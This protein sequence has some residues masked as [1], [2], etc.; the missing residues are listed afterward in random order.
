MNAKLPCGTILVAISLAGRPMIALAQPS[1]APPV[2]AAQMPTYHF[3][4]PTGRDCM[5]FDPNGAIFYK[6]RYHLGYIYQEG[7]RHFWG[8]VSSTDLVHW[9][10]HPPMLSPGPES[11]IFSGN[12]F[13]DKKGRVVL[14]YHGLGDAAAKVPAG[15]CLAIAQDDDLDVFRKLE[16][17]PVMKN[18]GWDPHT[19]QENGTYYSIS[20]GN[21]GSGN[22]PSLY[23]STDDELA[24]W[25]LVGPL[26]SR[27][28]PGVF[29]NEDIS[30][31]DL[32]QL[33][34]KH[35]LLCI[36]HIRGARYYVGRF[37]SHQFR[38][39]AHYRMNW[40]GGTCFAPETLRDGKGRRIMWAWVLGSPSTMSLPRVLSM[41]GDGLM[42]IE[43]VEELNTLRNNR[44]SLRNKD[45][46]IDA[47]VVA[48][49]IHGDCKELQVSI[50]PQQSAECGV[51][52]RCSP[53]GVEETVIA[54]IPG[55]KILRIQMDK[56]SL[57]RSAKPRTYAMTFML[58]QGEENPEV[59]AQEAPFELSPKEL[60]NLHIYLDHSIMEVFANGR[61]CLT[62]RIWPTR[63]D[64]DRVCFFS[65]G[66]S[67]KVKSLEAWDMGAISL[68]PLGL[69][70]H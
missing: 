60:L 53:D 26:M 13:L 66:G 3:T 34:P 47:Q 36:S 6:G 19:W 4:S 15:N 38:P 54:Y 39:E 12:A 52:V 57:D 17:N 10:M 45:V 48:V 21:P 68:S 24:K 61:Q 2:V 9:R 25:D 42:H 5:P 62:Q 14:S 56:S 29:P 58:P 65:R 43:P 1:A 23:T 67:A 51:K 55:R 33:G 11:G 20:G 22:G 37:E 27:E 49:G 50:D 32:F 35:I 8:H 18:P 70:S 59:S 40:P 28:M 46:P 41:G 64:S 44:R 31:P 69:G 16:A 63:T 30:C 7:G